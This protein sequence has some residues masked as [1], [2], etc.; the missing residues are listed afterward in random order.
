MQSPQAFPLP[1][2]RHRG[3]AALEEMEEVVGM[4]GRPE[5]ASEEA[6]EGI[7]KDFLDSGLILFFDFFDEFWDEEG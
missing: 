5:A 1:Y 4:G 2:S 6:A 3:E 7:G